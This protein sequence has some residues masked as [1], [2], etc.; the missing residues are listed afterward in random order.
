MVDRDM[1]IDEIH[2]LTGIDHQTIYELIYD[3]DFGEDIKCDVVGS[4]IVNIIENTDL[5]KTKIKYLR[6]TIELVVRDYDSLILD[7]YYRDPEYVVEGSA[8]P[9][10]DGCLMAI[11]VFYFEDLESGEYDNESDPPV[12]H[13]PLNS[14]RYKFRTIKQIVDFMNDDYFDLLIPEIDA[15]IEYYLHM[16]NSRE[17]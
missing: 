2:D 4:V 13:V 15:S 6:T 14:P 11:D 10:M 1:S 17:Q 8:T 12:I 9:F 16:I 5:I 3:H 7:F